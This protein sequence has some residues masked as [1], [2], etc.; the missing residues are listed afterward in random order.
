L[1]AHQRGE[2]SYD[3]ATSPVQFAGIAA[4]VNGTTTGVMRYADAG[5]EESLDEAARRGINHF[6]LP[7]S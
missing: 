7:P 6:Q 1:I 5:Y 2:L 3:S 4:A